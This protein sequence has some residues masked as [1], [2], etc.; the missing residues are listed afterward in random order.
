MSGQQEGRG[1]QSRGRRFGQGR[2]DKPG[3]PAA[4][5]GN[6]SRYTGDRRAG[7]PKT[8]RG[9][10]R[11]DRN[12]EET[13]RQDGRAGRR[14]DARG[15]SPRRSAS[16][17][18][19]D[20]DDRRKR[21]FRGDG[22]R[23]G[24]AEYSRRAKPSGPGERRA[25]DRRDTSGRPSRAGAEERSQRGRPRTG[26][27]ETGRRGD[28]GKA[29]EK[30]DRFGGARDRD[31]DRDRDRKRPGERGGYKSGRS[32][33]GTTDRGPR[34]EKRAGESQQE[35]SG[36][37]KVAENRQ[38][39][40]RPVDPTLPDD[41]TA[42][43]LDPEA[44]A[45]LRSLP[46]DLAIVVARHLVMAGRLLDEDPERAYL[47]AKTARRLGS[48]V[49]VVRE[50][51][52]IAA[53]QAGHWAEALA[54]LRAARRLSGREA[55]L[56]VMAD[57]ERG[58]GRPE[59]ALSLARSPEAERLEQAERVEMRIVE[60]GARRDM[61]QYD[62]AVLVLQT[63]ELKEQR[64]RP[65]SARLLYSYADALSAAGRDDEAGEWFARAAAADR[66]GETDAAERYAELAGLE[67]LDND[68]FIDE[69]D[70]GA[71]GQ[72]AAKAPSDDIDQP[73]AP[74]ASAAGQRDARGPAAAASEPGSETPEDGAAPGS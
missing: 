64:L 51:S 3:R 1:D 45:G 44:W 63:P 69:L 27:P 6:K 59:R 36:V 72:V 5:G 37:R 55:Y 26:K 54:E 74:P 65:W 46:K 33:S 4:R 58:L 49:A 43:Q 50:G 13:K 41:V 25:E 32:G 70:D 39:T 56:P 11:S 16:G 73:V 12:S 31:R 21:P 62:A 10:P 15:S 2:K 20:G 23:S 42:E 53:Y 52:G 38:R 35:R 40:D 47:H 30:R 14:P 29:G 57:C 24:R 18:G 68:D 19:R 67:I 61:G 8:G 71:D 17:G 66:D 9:G 7:G 22:E 28:W 48:R 60:S 34:K